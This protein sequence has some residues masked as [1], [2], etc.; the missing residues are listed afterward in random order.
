MHTRWGSGIPAGTERPRFP[1][2]GGAEME[3]VATSSY[4]RRG[5]HG[6]LAVL[7]G[8]D[9]SNH[10]V[11][12]RLQDPACSHVLVVGGEGSARGELLRAC[13]ISL[14]VGV[15]PSGLQLAGIDRTGRELRVLE[16]LPQAMAPLAETVE[17]ASEL[18]L[19]LADECRR[20]ILRVYQRPEIV[21]LIE[22]LDPDLRQE[23]ILADRLEDVLRLGPLCGVHV[24]ASSN[25]RPSGVPWAAC[26]RVIEALEGHSAPGWFRLR[27][28][29]D[30]ATDFRAAFLGAQDLDGAVRWIRGERGGKRD[31]PTNAWMRRAT[32][33]DGW[34]AETPGTGGA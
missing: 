29:W 9:P 21:L 2:T 34:G 19:W 4:R 14:A 13:L 31:V 27:E 16:A 23:P 28:R 17:Q 22:G 6:G 30:R 7:L 3:S 12:L 18:L 33:V 11:W 26:A 5:G 20:R 15:S 32:S 1:E 24:L 10:P 8:A 25:R